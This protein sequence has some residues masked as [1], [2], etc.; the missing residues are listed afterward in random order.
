MKILICAIDWPKHDSWYIWDLILNKRTMSNQ[1]VSHN[2]Y[3]EGNVQSLG[4]E[5]EKGKATGGVMKKG[6]YTF[7]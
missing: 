2:V 7:K 3:F 4:L 5:T 1:V 6:N